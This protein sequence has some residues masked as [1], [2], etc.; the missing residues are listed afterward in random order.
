LKWL[1]FIDSAQG[2]NVGPSLK[3]GIASVGVGLRYNLKKDISARF[4]VAQVVDGYS[5]PG[6]NV[7]PEGSV[8]GHVGVAFGF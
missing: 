5:P 4:D 1:A 7:Q 3:V 8:R 2:T 6:N